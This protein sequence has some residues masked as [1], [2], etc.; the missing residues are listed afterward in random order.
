MRMG[1]TLAPRPATALHF[2]NKF[3]TQILNVARIVDN[4]HHHHQDSNE[5]K[6]QMINFLG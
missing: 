1:S 4:I 5:I 3:K 6:P 2:I